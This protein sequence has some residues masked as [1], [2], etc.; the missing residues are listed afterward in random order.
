MPKRATL[1]F[2]SD[3][4]PK[5][6]PSEE[7]HVYYCKWSGRHAFTTTC[8]LTKAPRRRTDDAAVIDTQ[9]YQLKLYTSEA[10]AKLIKRKNGAIE[11]QYRLTIGKLPIGYR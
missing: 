10:G 4:A 8:N 2:S 1:T 11:K 3:D 6:A 9:K 7:L 5:V